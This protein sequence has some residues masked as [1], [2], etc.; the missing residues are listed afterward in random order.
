MKKLI[1]LALVALVV[2][3]CSKGV[4]DKYNQGR[5]KQEEKANKMIEDSAE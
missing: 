4:E 3:G 5:D 1:A 2:A